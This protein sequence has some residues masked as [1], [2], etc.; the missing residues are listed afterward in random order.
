MLENVSRR[1]FIV[2]VGFAGAGSMLTPQLVEVASLG[3][4]EHIMDKLFDDLLDE[5]PVKEGLTLP[6]GSVVPT[7]YVA[8]RNRLNRI[9][10]GVGSMPNEHSYEKIMQLWSEK[11]AARE[12]E[13]PLHRFF[14][15]MDYSAL[16]DRSIKECSRSNET[17]PR[18]QSARA[19][20][21]GGGLA[22]RRT[23][24]VA[25]CRPHLGASA[26]LSTGTR[27]R[28]STFV[29]HLSKS[30]PCRARPPAWCAGYN[31]RPTPRMPRGGFA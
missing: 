21:G 15:A 10:S 3:I 9:A 26:G 30:L 27:A 13:M 17:G 22:E 24:R 19:N 29:A 20:S 6:N 14:T 1:R 31:G 2:S 8:L 18:P 16:T 28:T 7:V 25:A 23:P 12:L 11:D 5:T 4:N